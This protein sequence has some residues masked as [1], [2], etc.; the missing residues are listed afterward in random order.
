LGNRCGM[1]LTA[2]G[3]FW[4]SLQIFLDKLYV[5]ALALGGPGLFFVAVADSSF[6]S[7]PE[8]ND[9]LIVVL[10]TGQGWQ[11]MTYYVVM[12]TLGSVCGCALLYS[13]G[14]RGGVFMQRRLKTE[15]VNDLET[16]YRQWGMWAVVVPSILPPPTPFKIF[17]LSAGLFRL[18]FAKFLLAVAVGRSVRYFMWGILAVLY[19]QLA[20]NFMQQNL[21]AVGVGLFLLLA[22][23]I[24]GYA[25]MWTKVR[26]KS[27]RQE[28][29]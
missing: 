12:T 6:L 2:T 5:L 28:T 27:A 7:V 29:V 3:G 16:V 4:Y 14:R 10:S 22:G 8:G 26:K 23:A 13:V 25:V 18:P 1:F 17:V 19:G 20:K 15:R 24:T 21:P 9:L 11:L